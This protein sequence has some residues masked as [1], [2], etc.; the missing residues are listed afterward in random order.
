MIS[1]L[2]DKGEPIS[3]KITEGKENTFYYAV[4]YGDGTIEG[5]LCAAAGGFK[6]IW[7]AMEQA[8][9]DYL[10]QTEI[11]ACEHEWSPIYGKRHCV[12]CGVFDWNYK[13]ENS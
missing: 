5:C 2:R 12:L 8:T 3:I 4:Y 10:K 13:D 11:R 7:D 1:N 9:K 6:N